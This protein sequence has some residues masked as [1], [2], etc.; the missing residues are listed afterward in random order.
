[1]RIPR[2]R[3]RSRAAKSE[4]QYDDVQQQGLAASGR[5]RLAQSRDDELPW[6]LNSQGVGVACVPAADPVREC[7][8]REA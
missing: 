6:A 4:H 1:M 5:N 3:V 2:V 8:R 7:R